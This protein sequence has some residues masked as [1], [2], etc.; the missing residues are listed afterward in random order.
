MGSRTKPRPAVKVEGDIGTPE[1]RQHGR[2]VEEVRDRTKTGQVTL[3]GA[4]VINTHPLDWYKRRKLLG[5][6][7]WAAG[8]VVRQIAT[9]AKLEPHVISSYG[10]A[11][12]GTAEFA[13]VVAEARALLNKVVDHISTPAGKDA[14]WTVC[15]GEEF[16][17]S[18]TLPALRTA[19]GEL[20]QW[21]AVRGLPE[22][23]TG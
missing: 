7:E 2:V 4:R 6:A 9:R 22:L 15:V 10:Q 13:D 18:A 21:W 17:G 14:V 3:T 1:R 16:C 11:R 23:P 20:S 5:D 12:G 19:L 8:A